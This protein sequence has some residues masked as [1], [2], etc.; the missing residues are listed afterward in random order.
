[1]VKNSGQGSHACLEVVQR[2][3]RLQY[4][5]FCSKRQE[6]SEF[7]HKF[8]AFMLWHWFCFLYEWKS[9]SGSWYMTKWRLFG[10]I[11]LW[12]AFWF[13]NHTL[14]TFLELYKSLILFFNRISSSLNVLHPGI[15]DVFA[16]HCLWVPNRMHF[17]QLIN[18]VTDPK[19][20]SQ[21]LPLAAS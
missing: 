4:S 8:G 9:L 6:H 20:G 10:E 14:R 7:T 19:F 1:M 11:C 21:K 5:K 3:H 18:R 16:R 13:R 17:H 15:L 12:Q 2:S